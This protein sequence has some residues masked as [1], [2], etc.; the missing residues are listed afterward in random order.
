MKEKFA[1]ES[2]NPEIDEMLDVVQA[3]A[4]R[5]NEVLESFDRYASLVA[6]GKREVDLVALLDKLTRFLRPQAESNGI[7]IRLAA[8]PQRPATINADSVQLKQ[9]FLNLAL[10]AFAAMPAGG[11]LKIQIAHASEGFQIDVSDTGTGIPEEV[12]P[13]IFDPYFTTRSDGTGMGLAILRKDSPTT[14]W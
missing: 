9:V 11:V 13:R 8:D 2:T 7:T 4:K 10:N 5:L 1:E 6:Q 12:Q 3:E 14:R